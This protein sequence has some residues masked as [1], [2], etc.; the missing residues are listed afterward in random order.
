M[1]KVLVLLLVLG[2]LGAPV[3]G[4]RVAG[5]GEFAPDELKTLGIIDDNSFQGKYGYITRQ[6]CLVAIVNAIGMTEEA[7]RYFCEL[8]YYRPAFD[9]VTS[10]ENRG[11]VWG[12]EGTIALGDGNQHF[13]PNHT[14]TYKEA[15]AFMM[16]CLEQCPPDLDLML[17]RAIE[18]GLIK[19]TDHFYENM[20][21][22]FYKQDFCVLL[23]RFI[24]QSRFAYYADY[25]LYEGKKFYEGSWEYN[26]DELRSMTYR[27]FLTSRLNNVEENDVQ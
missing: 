3:C 14:A 12:A 4:I 1:K 8:A 25:Y 18:I 10:D 23:E 7:N 20:D 24:G 2:I 9:D 15:V 17:S 22:Y 11:Y 13:F 21:A 26:Q 19:E 16:R 27:E 6:E 5:N